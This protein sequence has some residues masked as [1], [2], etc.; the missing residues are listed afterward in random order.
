MKRVAF[1]IVS[2][3]AATNQVLALPPFFG[4]AD[5]ERQKQDTAVKFDP[6][7][8]VGMGPDVGGGRPREYMNPLPPVLQT[9][10]RLPPGAVNRPRSGPF[11]RKAA[12]RLGSRSNN[13]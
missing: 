13:Q 11:F 8:S 4:N 6:Y 12:L 3:L 1:L 9:Q 2:L 7:P 10:T 5:M